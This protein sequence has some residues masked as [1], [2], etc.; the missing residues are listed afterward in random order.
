MATRYDCVPQTALMDALPNE[1]LSCIIQCLRPSGSPVA[2]PA[3]HEIAQALLALTLVSSK[4]RSLAVPYL[5]NY[6]LYIDSPWR[7][8]LLLGTLSREGNILQS[9][10]HDCDEVA[11]SGPLG[12]FL[13]AHGHRVLKSLY[14]APFEMDTI[15]EL[16]VVKMI[17]HLFELLSPSLNRLVI[18][19]PLRS[20][21][22]DDDTQE[23]RPVLR[24]A[25]QRLTALKE[26]VS[27]R[28]ELYLATWVVEG[29]NLEREPLVWSL[30]PQ[31]EQLALYNVDICCYRFLGSLK[32]LPNLK[33]LV[34]TR[35]DGEQDVS[36]LDLITMK[37]LKRL[38]IVNTA[39]C[40]RGSPVIIGIPEKLAK[41]QTHAIG[42]TEIVR[43]NVPVLFEDG[44]GDEQQGL[45]DIES[46]QIWTRETGINGSLWDFV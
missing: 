31:L 8:Q 41:N 44:N 26:F 23:I 17:D 22:P 33:V 45:G 34:L 11:G 15:D 14:L 42:E 29:F 21:Y 30:W 35:A 28:D 37:P 5:Y 12:T 9:R 38:L 27:A 7:L 24:K 18:D 2:I 19:M 13:L 3:S 1:L 4:I 16:P 6:C 39:S 20:L 32:Q 25:F 10:Q 36:A 43:V 40:H 46:C